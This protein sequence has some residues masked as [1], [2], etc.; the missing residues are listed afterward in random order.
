MKGFCEKK[1]YSMLLSGT[2]TKAVMYLMLL[3]DSII[4][5]F[6]IG[7]SGVAGINAITPVTAIV[8]FFGDLVSTGVGIVYT[9]EIGAMRKQRADEIYSQGLSISI[10]IGLISA[11]LIFI[12]RSLYFGVSGITGETLEKALQY[13]RFIP[14]N[15]FLTIVIFY[16][17]QMVY[18]DGD[19]LCNNICYG[20]QIGGN[21][22]CS[23]VLAGFMGMTG[24]ILGSVIGNA[25]GILTCFWH[26]FR[27]S[28]TLH[29]VWHLSFK[30]FLLTSKYSIVDSSVYICWGLMDYVMIGFISRHYGNSG[31]IALAVVV[32]LIEFGV[33]MDGVGMAMQPLIGTY[34]G[35]KNHKLIKRV[36]RSGI[37][38]AV[39]EGAL[40]TLLIWIFSRQ[41][42]GLFGVSGGESLT[43]SM[44]AI[45]IVSLGFIF[46]SSVSLT[47]SYYM[48]VDHIGMATG[49]ACIQN[50]FLYICLPIV[51]SVLIGSNGMWAGFVLAPILT[52]I[53]AMFYVYQRFGRENFPFL[54]KEMD[55]EI[56]VMDEVLT[57]ETASALSEQTEQHLLSHQYPSDTAHRAALF[58]EEIGLSIIERNK[59]SKKP[60]LIELSLFFEDSEVLII[61]RDSGVLFDLTDPDAEIRGLSG[62]I[63]SGLMEAHR[64]KTYLVTTGYNR[65]M[66][67]FR[68]TAQ[69]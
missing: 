51:G 16:L 50:G 56:I 31:L 61:E 60:L 26:Y 34:F 22:I 43:S 8:T 7:E 64:E 38:A 30:D 4:A 55:S 47:T 33:V 25:L 62:F 24:I 20:F 29:F 58:A 32:S 69:N 59:Q 41:F 68:Q 11:A 42:C 15:A 49:I 28:S 13:Y 27:K 23:V 1:F 65:N 18:S 37:K 3:S 48:L 2:F 9:R 46:C 6:F 39:A 54:L 14:I 66:I 10:G 35:E 19:E 44:T 45:R 17:E 67:R 52:L 5:G 57:P 12:I 63:L 36:M 53:C 40:A 21:I